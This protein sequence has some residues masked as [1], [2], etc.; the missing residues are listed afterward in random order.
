MFPAGFQAEGALYSHPYTRRPGCS[1]AAQM[2][3]PGR[4]G[5]GAP[6]M[7]KVGV[8]DSSQACTGQ[9]VAR[10]P[11]WPAESGVWQGTPAVLPQ[12]CCCPGNHTLAVPG[13]LQQAR[14]EDWSVS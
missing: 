2:M 8:G 1:L 11:Q 12:S 4:L 13:G 7:G 3:C 5:Q 10:V 6:E 14:W 9:E